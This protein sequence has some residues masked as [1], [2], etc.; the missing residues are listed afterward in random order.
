[1]LRNQGRAD[2]IHAEGLHHGY[3]VDVAQLFLGLHV[4][5]PVQHARSDDN[6]VK[7]VP[8]RCLGSSPVSIGIA[9]TLLLANLTGLRES[10]CTLATRSSAAS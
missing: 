3:G 8:G 7:F 5:A 6:E 2:G 4:R 10:A 9:I 1:M